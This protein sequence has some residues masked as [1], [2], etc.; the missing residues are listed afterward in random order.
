M[1][2]PLQ[3]AELDI[4]GFLVPWS[5]LIW[6]CG[7]IIAWAVAVLMERRGWTR[8]VWHLP[9]FFIAMVVFFSCMLGWF[10]AP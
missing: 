4:M 1:R 10:F 6:T 9:L 5:M 7:F 8:Y 3:T 2:V